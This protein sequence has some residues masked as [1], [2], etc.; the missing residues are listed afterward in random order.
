MTYNSELDRDTLIQRL[1]EAV[2]CAECGSPYT[3]QDVYIVAQDGE[4]WAV[5]AFCPACGAESVI[6]AY[7]DEVDAQDVTVIPAETP[8]D[9]P[10]TLAEVA[11]WRR[12]LAAFDG[13][14]RDLLAW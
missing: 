5:V 7:V 4:A 11:A 10:P 3:A 8:Q 13:D 6:L 14:L 1:L 12:F 9:R 2:S